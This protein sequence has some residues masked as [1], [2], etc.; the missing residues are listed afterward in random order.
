MTSDKLVEH[1]FSGYMQFLFQQRMV[2]C[3]LSFL[4][5]DARSAKRGIATLSRP[6]DCLPVT[7]MYCGRICWTSSKLIARV[8]SLRYSYLGATTSAI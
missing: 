3:D 6:F 7:L 8:I 2:C 4:P 5:H 1:W